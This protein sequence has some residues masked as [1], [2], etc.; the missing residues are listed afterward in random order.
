MTF[1]YKWWTRKTTKQWDRVHASEACKALLYCFLL[2]F[3]PRKPRLH[4]LGPT[5]LR[6]SAIYEY[7]EIW[8][9]KYRIHKNKVSLTNEKS[10]LN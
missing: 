1:L 2:I 5:V 3:L 10:V 8:S 7:D 9:T 6:V 4:A